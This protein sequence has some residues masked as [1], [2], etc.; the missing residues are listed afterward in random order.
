MDAAE[1]LRRTRKF[2]KANGLP[3]ELDASQ[4][5]GS[6]AMLYLGSRRTVLPMH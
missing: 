2:G 5:K 1:F 3:V 6:H 4:G